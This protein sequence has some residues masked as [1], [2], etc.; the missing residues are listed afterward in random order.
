[1]QTSCST[2]ATD[3]L[4]PGIRISGTAP[5]NVVYECV[6]KQGLLNQ[7]MGEIG[8][9]GRIVVGGYCLEPEE[10]Y[11]P[12]AQSKLLRVHFA[13]GETPADM[14]EARDAILGGKVDLRPWL[15][16]GIGLDDVEASLLRMADP[17]EP[18]RRVCD[19]TR[20]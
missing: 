4:A 8:P 15:G 2:R 9:G 11:V 13:G 17:A 10:I 19:P 3:H 5:P 20:V 18:I 16:E 1:M 12:T 7:I 6:G 14:I